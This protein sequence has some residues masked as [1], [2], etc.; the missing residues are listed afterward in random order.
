MNF[1]LTD[2]QAMLRDS[3]RRWTDAHY[4]FAQHQEISRDGS[5]DQARWR[6]MGSLG[7]LGISLPEEAGGLGQPLLETCIVAEELGRALVLEPFVPVAVL[8]GHLI[9]RATSGEQRTEWLSALIAG[10]GIIAVAHGENEARGDMHF[11]GTR[12][13]RSGDSWLLAGEKTLVYAA[14]SAR[15]YLISAR[16]EGSE[17]AYSGVSLF[18]VDPDAAGLVRRDYRTVDG[19][20]ASDLTLSDVVVSHDRV[21]GPQA[22]AMAAIEHATE[23]AI[24]A[25][26]AEAVGSM[27]QA[28]WLTRDYLLERRQ[29]GVRIGSF[30]ALQHRMAD[31][32]IRVQ[33]ARAAVWRALAFLDNSDAMQRRRAIATAKVQVGNAARFVCGQAVQLHGGLA[34][35]EQFRIGHYFRRMTVFDAT[36]GSA[37]A[38]LALIARELSHA[39]ARDQVVAP[40]V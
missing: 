14:E 18:A 21:I 20:R 11:V 12:A 9:D 1:Q 13:T 34:I 29:F 19:R 5:L 23:R 30:Q 27:D 24:I 40:A 7:W 38:H 6:D 4:S 8:A 16:V 36:F 15:S 33:V 3:V 2:E 25:L 28:L 26:C 17:T 35:T 22:G 39:R 10:D 37:H 32:Y 31:M